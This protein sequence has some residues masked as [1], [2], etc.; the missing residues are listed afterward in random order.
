VTSADRATSLI[1]TH[2]PVLGL[3]KVNLLDGSG[4]ILGEDI[5]ARYSIPSHDVSTMDG[6]AL[7]EEDIKDATP[8]NP[9]AFDV[10][11]ELKA[12]TKSKKEVKKGKAIRIMTGAILP[13]GADTVVKFEDTH[14]K[15]NTRVSIFNNPGYGANIK[16]AGEQIKA[17][18][19][20]IAK[21]KVLNP[22]S[23]GFIASQ[24]R[25][26]IYV[27]QKPRVAI[28]A[29]GDE[30]VDIDEEGGTNVCSNLYSIGAQVLA[31]GGIPVLLGIA[32][33]NKKDLTKKIVQGL[34][35]D[36]LITTG[37]VSLGDYDMVK[38]T[39][40]ELGIDLKFSNVKIY[41]GKSLLFG[42]LKEKPVFGLPGN[43]AAS[44]I[45]FE[46]FVHPAIR[47]IQGHT[48]LFPP[49]V[50]AYL[51]ETITKKSGYHYIK[52]AV[53]KKEEEIYKVTPKSNKYGTDLINS[54]IIMPENVTSLN[55]GELVEVQLLDSTY[56]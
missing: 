31:Y 2:T 23:I 8:E 22:A 46:I 14:Q 6:F 26:S 15:N 42:I 45:C 55:K 47:K 36:M 33:D 48:I 43:P 27:Y 9:V 1:L 13:Y 18:N 35:Q 21:G 4:R 39:L 49:K 11:E 12:G 5:F 3:E 25:F 38:D 51:K 30:L 17:G 41:P 52:E 16:R 53:L 44:M 50:K 32:K 19:L 10:I 28:L 20:L 40:I 56:V 24:R 34:S 29:T 7:K 37:G 54:L